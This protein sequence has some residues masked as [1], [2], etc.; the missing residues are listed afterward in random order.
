M[1][2]LVAKRILN[3]VARWNL[4][5]KARRMTT[6]GQIAQMAHNIKAKECCPQV[7]AEKAKKKAKK[8]QSGN[9]NFDFK[10]NALHSFFIKN[11]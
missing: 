2:L 8:C 3:K 11:C 5:K 9:P 1:K 10:P 6:S 4:Q 7:S